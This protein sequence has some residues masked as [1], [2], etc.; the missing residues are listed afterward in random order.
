M[1]A[2]VESDQSLE[3]DCPRR[4]RRGEEAKKASCG[5]PTIADIY[6]LIL[7]HG[8]KPQRLPIGD[9]VED[10]PEPGRLAEC[11]SSHA[12]DGIEQARN[13]VCDGAVFRMIA[14]KRERDACKDDTCVPCPNAYQ[15]AG[16]VSPGQRHSPMRFGANN[17]R[18]PTP[19]QR[20]GKTMRIGISRSSRRCSAR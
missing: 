20:S 19:N 6:Q 9:H 3:Q 8:S 10:G 14:H 12:V 11:P 5:T 15:P 4:V 18:R 17:F 16:R 7:A 1:T 13:N 2:K